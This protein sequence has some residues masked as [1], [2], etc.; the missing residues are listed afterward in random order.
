MAPLQAPPEKSLIAL[1]TA[2]CMLVSST[3]TTSILVS[4]MSSSTG[5]VLAANV[6]EHSSRF[7][8]LQLVESLERKATSLQTDFRTSSMMRSCNDTGFVVA[9]Q[10]LSSDAPLSTVPCSIIGFPE[11]DKEEKEDEKKGKSLL[12]SPLNQTTVFASQGT[13][14]TNVSLQPTEKPQVMTEGPLVTDDV[15]EALT[16]YF[17]LVINPII[18]AIGVVANLISAIV[19]SRSGLRKPSDIFLLALAVADFACMMKSLNFGW[20]LTYYRHKMPVNYLG[21]EMPLWAAYSCYVVDKILIRTSNFAAGMSAFTTVLITLERCLA[22]FLPLQFSNIVTPRRACLALVI[23]AL[24]LLPIYLFKVF[25]NGFLYYFHEKFNT[26][27]GHQRNSDFTNSHWDGVQTFERYYI[28]HFEITLPLALVIIGC[29]GISFKLTIVRNK[30]RTLVHGTPK[31]ARSALRTTK[32]LL[33]VCLLYSSTRICYLFSYLPIFDASRERTK[34]VS[35]LFVDVRW[36][37][38]EVNS[39]CNIV[40]Y[41]I[42]NPKF[43]RALKSLLVPRICSGRKHT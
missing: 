41:V 11:S 7:S 14:V 29:A 1:L 36:T 3:P 28:T 43:K 19:I 10:I 33:M 42:S 21:W 18:G 30:Q 35:Y 32:T 22:I 31:N 16:R 34:N 40:V 26:S 20:M 38:I 37:L 25:L 6:S 27:M 39:A 17:A 23:T 24:F 9:N 13:R 5:R 4:S 12:F 8:I 15:R 2:V